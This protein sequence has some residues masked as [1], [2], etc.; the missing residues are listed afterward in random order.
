MKPLYGDELVGINQQATTA[1]A[2]V[3]SEAVA[4][5]TLCQSNI[6]FEKKAYGLHRWFGTGVTDTQ[7]NENRIDSLEEWHASGGLPHSF[8]F[9]VTAGS[10][11]V[12]VGSERSC[13]R[14]KEV[15]Q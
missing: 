8:I 12:I 13:L 1:A 11:Y 6:S 5:A 2:P 4:A 7:A 10:I 3:L 14:R 9:A 15:R